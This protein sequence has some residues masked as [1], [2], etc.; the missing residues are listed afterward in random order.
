MQILW[1]DPDEYLQFH[2]LDTT[3]IHPEMYERLEASLREVH[4][5]L[6]LTRDDV[7]AHRKA[8]LKIL[9]ASSNARRIR[10]EEEAARQTQRA[11]LAAQGLSTYGLAPA[12][13][14]PLS[15]NPQVAQIPNLGSQTQLVREELQWP[16]A[17]SRPEF[18][19][20]S[21]ARLYELCIN[22]ADEGLRRGMLVTMKVT[23]ISYYDSNYSS[24]QAQD[25][26]SPLIREALKTAFPTRKAFFDAWIAQICNS[27]KGST[28]VRDAYAEDI[29]LKFLEGHVRR[30]DVMQD[31]EQVLDV[32]TSEEVRR[33]DELRMKRPD[34]E[35]SFVLLFHRTWCHG[36]FLFLFF[37]CY[38][39][40]FFMCVL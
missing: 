36:C 20:L 24:N 35:V 34:R 39:Y 37:Y 15:L 17:D 16:F 40:F 1:K 26:V 14:D 6:Q 7:A 31:I 18:H 29:I 27:H 12:P 8:M 11:E 32:V 30:V 5:E 33:A 10:R 38:C 9:W 4:T 21:D 19:V 25:K 3:R 2:P 23:R 22:D 28:E 13:F